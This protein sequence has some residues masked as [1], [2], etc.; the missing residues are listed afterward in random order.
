MGE[1]VEFPSNGHTCGGY[2]ATPRSGRGPG[3]VVIQEW[4]GLVDHIKDVCDRFA[5]EGFVALAPDLFHGEGASNQEPDRAGKLAQSLKLEEA[6]RD[7]G[8]AVKWLAE[9]ERTSGNK[10]GIVGFCLGGA[11]A[12][13]AA[14]NNPQIAAT[15]AFYPGL[16]WPAGQA[17]DPTRIQGA[18]LGHFATHDDSYTREQVDDLL[19]RLEE[20]GVD[21]EFFWYEAAGHAFFNDDRPDVHHP[22]HAQLAWDRTLAFFRKHLVTTATPVG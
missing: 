10:V 4:W 2:L 5:S 13:Y 18:V 19:R 9:S 1:M 3:V 7:I 11:L 21:V 22:D 16:S 8:G 17:A 12:L 15:V 14:S 20:A 6:G